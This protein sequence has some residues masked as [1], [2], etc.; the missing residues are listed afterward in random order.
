MKLFLGGLAITVT[1]LFNTG[2]ESK[3]TDEQVIAAV[4]AF[5]AKQLSDL[6]IESPLLGKLAQCFLEIEN[7]K[8][9]KRLPNGCSRELPG[10]P[11]KT[12]S[13]L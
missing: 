6:A 12:T 1:V 13:C 5:H 2:C 3:P 7:V 11:M 8:V 9:L 10:L 4:Q